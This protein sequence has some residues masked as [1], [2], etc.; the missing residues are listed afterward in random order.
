MNVRYL[1]GRIFKYPKQIFNWW[2]QIGELAHKYGIYRIH[3]LLEF[4]RLR[5]TTGISFE[6]YRGYGLSDPGM[7]WRKKVSYWPSRWNKLRKIY[8]VLNPKAYHCILNNK[9]IFNQYFYSIG[10]PVVKT[11]GFMDP[12]FGT[13]NNG[14]TLRTTKELLGGIW[15]TGAQKNGFVLKHV[16]GAQGK[17]V[18]VFLGKDEKHPNNLISISGKRY[19][20]AM[21]AKEI[22][23]KEKRF[24]PGLKSTWI[25][26]ERL[27]SHPIIEE[28]SGPTVACVRMQTLSLI[29]SGAKVIGCMMKIPN[30]A[31]DCDN[32]HYGGIA[33]YVD[34]ESGELGRGRLFTEK[35]VVW[36]EH[37]PWNGKK[38]K[39]VNL[40]FWE[41]SK[42]IVLRAANVFPWMRCIGWDIAITTKGPFIIEGNEYG[43]PHL[44][45]S[46]SSQGLGN[47]EMQT[48]FS[49]LNQI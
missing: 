10:L 38:F 8:D 37:L 23:D 35:D 40:P 18:F 2:I 15:Q 21:L 49:S 20:A 45:Q 12:E 25:I 28:L 6:E 4:L 7:T 17:Q 44:I 46:V 26:E 42:K 29:N 31:R 5:K 32:L 1:F 30:E 41:E 43:S 13:F 9:L 3:I 22:R 24:E 16:E 48:V 39:H 47:D 34:P 33:V 36:H 27:K 14:D 19:T 11:Y